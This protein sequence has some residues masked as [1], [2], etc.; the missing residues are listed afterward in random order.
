[1]EDRMLGEC[2]IS[3]LC[4]LRAALR[5][6]RKALRVAKRAL[7]E[8]EAKWDTHGDVYEALAEIRRAERK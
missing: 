3:D 6:T 1:M 4:D 8:I 2:Y 5:R 7:I